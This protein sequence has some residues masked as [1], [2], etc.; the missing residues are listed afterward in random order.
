MATIQFGI[1]ISSWATPQTKQ[2]NGSNSQDNRGLMTLYEAVTDNYDEVSRTLARVEREVNRAI[3]E[4]RPNVAESLTKV[5]M[6]LV[7][8]KAEAALIRI[9]SHPS[10]LP[11]KVRSEILDKKN[12]ALERWQAA[13]DES[14]RFHYKVKRNRDLG[15]ALDHDV[16]AKRQTLLNLVSSELEPLITFRNKLA[17]GQWVKP[18][19]SDLSKVEVSV[20]QGILSENSL[21]L[22]FHNNLIEQLTHALGDLIQSPNRFEAMFSKRFSKIR[23]NRISLASADF[24]SWK[25]SVRQT[26]KSFPQ[27][28]Q[29]YVRENGWKIIDENGDDVD[30]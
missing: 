22:K 24:A 9:I 5:Q 10:G 13:I 16:Q 1:A 29:A 25:S 4:N 8:I 2:L 27:L 30:L 12:N 7:S 19:N 11:P 6:L 18:L 21:S 17:H 3:R 26:H 28:V 23:E 20:L 15:Q 14:F